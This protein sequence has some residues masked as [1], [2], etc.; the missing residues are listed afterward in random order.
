MNEGIELM[1]LKLISGQIQKTQLKQLSVFIAYS[2]FSCCNSP[3]HHHKPLPTPPSSPLTMLA[4][5]PRW[6]TP[7]LL[8][9][10]YCMEAIPPA[11]PKRH[12][13]RNNWHEGREWVNYELKKKR[14][15][16]FFWKRSAIL[17][18]GRERL[19]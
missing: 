6:C 8:F 19:G 13:E 4:A 2:G 14:R 11:Y 7:D 12:Q 17:C 15:K 9:S 10:G 5:S 3:L 18:C 16:T 1:T